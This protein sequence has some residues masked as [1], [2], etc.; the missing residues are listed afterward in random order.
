[1]D[2]YFDEEDF[3]FDGIGS[4]SPLAQKVKSNLSVCQNCGTKFEQGFSKDS[5]G[6]VVAN[7]Y[8]LCEKCRK[9]LITNEV[10]ATKKGVGNAIMSKHPDKVYKEI[11]ALGK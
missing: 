6:N 11:K 8:K 5:Q 2:N 7:H 1:M 10:V 3:L 9:E 4:K